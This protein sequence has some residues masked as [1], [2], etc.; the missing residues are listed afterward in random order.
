M[1]SRFVPS[2][3]SFCYLLSPLVDN[4]HKPTSKV[5]HCLANIWQRHRRRPGCSLRKGSLV[6]SH[7]LLETL[8]FQFLFL[9]LVGPDHM[10]KIMGLQNVLNKSS[11][12]QK[13]EW[14]GGT[15][16]HQRYWCFIFSKDYI[17]VDKLFNF[18]EKLLQKINR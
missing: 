8:Q 12:T 13:E 7:L 15:P 17:M 1:R 5:N 6:Y 14:R 9:R 10:S 3:I 18:V 2:N 16:L 4:T 11:P